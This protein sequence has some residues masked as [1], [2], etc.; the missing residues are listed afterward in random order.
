MQLCKSS[1]KR[2]KV[3]WTPSQQAPNESLTLEEVMAT[4]TSNEQGGGNH[5]AVA[6]ELFVDTLKAIMGKGALLH[7]ADL[8]PGQNSSIFEMNASMALYFSGGEKC[9]HF[10]ASV[11]L[12]CRGL[13]SETDVHLSLCKPLCSQRLC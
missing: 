4:P 3:P 1:R 13:Q 12:C 7:K 5:G 8:Q 6:A 9:T 2:K 11:T 10:K